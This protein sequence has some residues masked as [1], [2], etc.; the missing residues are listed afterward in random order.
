MIRAAGSNSE[1]PKPTSD[2]ALPSPSLLAIALAFPALAQNKFVSKPSRTCSL[3]PRDA[4]ELT[5]VWCHQLHRLRRDVGR[6]RTG[7]A[8]KTWWWECDLHVGDQHGRRKR[9]VGLAKRCRCRKVALRPGGWIRVER[10]SLAS[11]GVPGQLPSWWTTNS[12]GSSGSPPMPFRCIARVVLTA[13]DLVSVNPSRTSRKTRGTIVYWTTT[14]DFVAGAGQRHWLWDATSTAATNFANA[15]GPLA[16]PYGSVAGRWI[17]CK[18]YTA[19]D[20]RILV[21]TGLYPDAADGTVN[22]NDPSVCFNSV[23][24]AAS[25]AYD[26]ILGEGDRGSPQRTVYL[27]RTDLAREDPVQ[28]SRGVSR[29]QALGAGGDGEPVDRDDATIGVHQPGSRRRFVPLVGTSGSTNFA[30]ADNWY[31]LSD[32]MEVEGPESSSSTRPIRA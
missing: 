7:T 14:G 1:F 22:T 11:A 5:V 2:H 8:K 30:I 17:E 23:Y 29:P 12:I 6:Y 9:S 32:D 31:G 25:S 26:P 28:V 27:Q 3:S 21:M 4:G 10:V 15:G 13:T 19:T 20:A 16:W 24:S 18:P